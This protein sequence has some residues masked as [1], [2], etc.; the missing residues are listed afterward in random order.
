MFCWKRARMPLP[1]TDSRDSRPITLLKPQEPLGW[2]GK[3][4]RTDSAILTHTHIRNDHGETALELAVAAECAPA[5]SLLA[6]AS[7]CHLIRSRGPE[8]ARAQV[9]TSCSGGSAAW[10]H[11]EISGQTVLDVALDYEYADL[12]ATLV[13]PCSECLNVMCCRMSECHSDIRNRAASECLN[14]MTARRSVAV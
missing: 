14:V 11:A 1:G 4:S 9:D 10:V 7:V 12:A 8:A 5:I 2:V 3:R 13:L 6:A